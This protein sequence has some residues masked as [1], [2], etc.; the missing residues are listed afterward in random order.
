M[1]IE[2]EVLYWG[3]VIGIE[4]GVLGLNFLGYPLTVVCAGMIYQIN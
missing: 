3:R 1:C 2:V 4:V